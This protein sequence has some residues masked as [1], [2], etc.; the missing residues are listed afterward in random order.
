VDECKPLSDGARLASPSDDKTV[1]IW[2]AF[3]VSG[4]QLARLDGHAAGVTSCAWSPDG[5]QLA[6][7]S[8]DATVSV[9]DA[10]TW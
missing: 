10:S 6:S 1:R 9:W 5:M 7:A 2:D 3:S 4:R 8:L